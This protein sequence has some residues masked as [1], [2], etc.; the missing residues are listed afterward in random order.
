MATLE[1]KGGLWKGKANHYGKLNVSG[2]DYDCTLWKLHGGNGLLVM[3][4]KD[5]AGKV[6][7]AD[8]LILYPPEKDGVA[9]I[10]SGKLGTK[11]NLIG[12]INVYKSDSANEKAPALNLTFKP[13]N[14]GVTTSGNSSSCS[15]DF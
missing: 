13:A 8:E 7:Q 12:Y 3:R 6:L 9:C 11:D 4:V 2:T 5:T 10:L 15:N 14:N 1:N